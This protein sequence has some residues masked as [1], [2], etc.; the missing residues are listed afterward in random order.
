MAGNLKGEL[1]RRDF[2]KVRQLQPA[3]FARA[4]TR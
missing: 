1:T 3:E 2:C 4:K